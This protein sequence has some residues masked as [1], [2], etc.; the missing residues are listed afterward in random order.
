MAAERGLAT[1]INP[2]D[3]PVYEWKSDG[4]AVRT[5]L[6]NFTRWELK[7][8]YLQ[9]DYSGQTEPYWHLVNEPYDYPTSVGLGAATLP[10]TIQVHQNF[11]NPF[12]S[13]TS[14]EF[15]LP[16][17]G[18]VRIDVIDVYGQVIEILSEG[19]LTRG[20][21]LI[22]WDASHR[23]SGLYFYRTLYKGAQTVRS[24]VLIR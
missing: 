15:I 16:N 7:T 11:P 1:I 23:A 24:M 14:I 10:R 3:I 19:F 8:Y 6:E 2:R 5:P 18:D 21:H 12:N 22:R 20:P 17:D 4:T 9:R 13:T